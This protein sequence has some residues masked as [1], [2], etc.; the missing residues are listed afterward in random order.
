MDP[1]TR[2]DTPIA[3]ID[4]MGGWFALALEDLGWIDAGVGN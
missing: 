3:Q 1:S 4:E 2:P